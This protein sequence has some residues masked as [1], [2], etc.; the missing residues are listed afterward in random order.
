M[1][2]LLRS[3]I[4]VAAAVLLA[5]P[6]LAQQPQAAPY[7]LQPGDEIAVEVSPQKAFSSATVVL[8]DGV[9]FLKRVGKLRA[10]GKTLDGLAAEIKRLLE[11]DLKEPEVLVT[12]T[13]MAPPP[14]QNKITVVGAVTNPGARDLETGM[15]LAKAL[16]L[17]GG[18]TREADLRHVAVVRR[19]LSRLEIDLSLPE[20]L[21]DP[22]RNIELREGDSIYIPV[23]ERITVTVGGA[24]AKSG[25]LELDEAPRVYKAIELAGGVAQGAD[26]SK[27]VIVHQDLTRTVI[28]LSTPARLSDPA[29]NRLVRDGDSIQ[30]PLRYETGIVSI[31]GA[32]A[33]PGSFE[34]KPN[35]TLEQLIVAAGKL[36]TLANVEN[37]QV[38]RMGKPTLTYNLIERQR[39]GMAEPIFLEPGDA[40]LIPEHKNR[41]LLAGTVPM[42]G[43]R[44]V[45]P[46]ETLHEFFTDPTSETAGA[47][48][49]SRA[50]LAKAEIIRSGQPS[51][52]VNLREVL[53]NPKSKHNLALQSGDVIFIPGKE[54]RRPSPL[55]QGFGLLG[56]LASLFRFGF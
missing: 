46:G 12:L 53:K 42:P 30:V 48:D 44:P 52:R 45:R 56:T 8:P 10:A 35:M 17:A 55:T 9:I 2:R 3:V 50:N 32:V 23:R 54:E 20:H 19:D 47:L 43:L 34:L 14:P 7:K 16:E 5:V 4:Q 27:V 25:P 26:L 39:Q 31:A 37:I 24:V 51:I 13:K 1:T 38:Q 18:T 29:H 33:N 41:V 6:A 11:E 21:S 36:N 49:T 28:D 15:R 22:K 40:V